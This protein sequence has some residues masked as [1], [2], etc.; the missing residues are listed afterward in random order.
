M[1]DAESAAWPTE[2]QLRAP[3][4]AGSRDIGDYLQ[5]ATHLK[6]PS[7]FQEAAEIY[8]QGLRLNLDHIDQAR[9]A[10]ELGDLLDKVG[11]SA[12]AVGVVENAIRL[13][14]DEP[15]SIDILT[16]R[17][18]SYTLLAHAL[19]RERPEAALNAPRQAAELL[20]NLIAL[21]P[22]TDDIGVLLEDAAWVHA[23]LGNVDRAI[24]LCE[25]YL[26]REPGPRHRVVALLLLAEA[27][28]LATRFRDA[29]RAVAEVLESPELDPR[30][31]PVLY[32]TLGLI[33][34][35][36][37]EPLKAQQA[38]ETSLKS[39]RAHPFQSSS[40][41]LLRTVFP[42]RLPVWW[43]REKCAGSRRGSRSTSPCY[44]VTYS[45]RS[46]I[47]CGILRPRTFVR[48]SSC[49]SPSAC[50]EIWRVAGAAVRLSG[51]RALR[52][53]TSARRAHSPARRAAGASP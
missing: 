9:L 15:D 11:R 49:P 21:H 28:R 10:W 26:R 8:E 2:S 22:D 47:E 43:R 16:L 27:L 34:R 6:D 37:N 23:S 18:R 31:H 25:E 5:L 14:R 45:A 33:H 29:E 36:A 38:F 4:A 30:D 46:M 12:E 53:A 17:A 20:D 32:N 1:S 19:W 42:F 3:I 35:G 7:R 13:L 50:L 48:P 24:A 39:L 52:R 40:Q 41:E 44:S 51:H